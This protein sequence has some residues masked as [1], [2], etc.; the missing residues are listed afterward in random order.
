MTTKKLFFITVDKKKIYRHAANK[1]QAAKLFSLIVKTF[2]PNRKVKEV[3]ALTLYTY[4]VI[5]GFGMQPNRIEVVAQS[6]RDAIRYMKKAFWEVYDYSLICYE[7]FPIVDDSRE[8]GS[9]RD[10]T[11]IDDPYL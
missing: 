9:V 7:P 8:V 4:A 2:V 5:H 6:E 11:L 1:E 3:K 10:V